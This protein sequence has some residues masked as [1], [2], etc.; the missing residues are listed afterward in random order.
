M[1]M[2]GV[3]K[4]IKVWVLG[5]GLADFHPTFEDWL[6][7]GGRLKGAQA[8]GE[9]FLGDFAKL[10]EF[11]AGEAALAGSGGLSAGEFG[12]ALRLGF[13]GN[14]FQVEEKP[15]GFA[16]VFGPIGFMGLGSGKR[17]GARNAKAEE[18]GLGVGLWGGFAGECF[19][20]IAG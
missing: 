17:N 6:D 7:A 9:A 16:G 8:F 2:F 4:Y 5:R 13:Y 11:G 12:D 14:A 20:R 10:D 15:D 19:E 1:F 3:G 18:N